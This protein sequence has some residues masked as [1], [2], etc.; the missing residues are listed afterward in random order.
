MT[1]SMWPKQDFAEENPNPVLRITRE[2]Q[3]L[4][5]N[6]SAKKVMH[7]FGL[8]DD[9]AL[10]P[11]AWT[12]SIEVACSMRQRVDY[13]CHAGEA[14][15]MLTFVPLRDGKH[16]NVYGVDI[17]H[18]KWVENALRENEQQMRAIIASMND[19]VF[20]IDMDGRFVVYHGGSTQ[21]NDT[22]LTASA[23]VG[24]RYQDVLLPE[25]GEKLEDA[26][27]RVR[28][29]LKA[30][31]FTYEQR[32]AGETH[33]FEAR[34][35]PLI[36]ADIKLTGVTVVVSDVSNAVW[37]RQRSERLL[38]LETLHHQIAIQFLQSE[39]VD[40]VLNNIM[41]IVGS[42]LDVSRVYVFQYQ[43]GHRL[44]DNTHEWCAPGVSPEIQELQ[45]I[46]YD[47]MVPSF[48]PLLLEQ[49]SIAPRHISELPDDI[50]AILSP[51]G[52]QTL[53]IVPI[54]LHDRLHGF[55]GMDE[56]RGPR[57]W[58]TE[59]ASLLRLI[60]NSF[61]RALEQNA[62]RLA[63]IEAHD[64][65]IQS[66]KL[67]SEF[68]AKMSHEIR[69]PMTG[70]LGMLELLRETDLDE[71]QTIF[72]RD[73]HDSATNLLALVDDVLDFSK[74]EA[75]RLELVAEP[76]DLRA[77]I[78]QVRTTLL[79]RVNAKGL[80]FEVEVEPQIPERVLGDP[81]RLRQVLMNLAGNAVKFTA[82][83]EVRI[84]V[85]QI[86]EFQGRVRLR[87][88]VEDSGI[89]IADE[90]LNR[91]FDSFVQAD[92]SI[93]RSFGGSGLGLTISKLLVEL[94]GGEIEVASTPGQGSTF[95]FSLTLPVQS[96]TQQPGEQIFEGLRT[97]V[98]GG[99]DSGRYLLA[100]QL[101][102]WQ[103]IVQ[104]VGAVVDL[105]AMLQR[106]RQDHAPFKLLLIFIEQP[107]DQQK[108]LLQ[109]VHQAMGSEAPRIYGIVGQTPAAAGAAYDGLLRRPVSA[110]DLLNVLNNLVSVGHLPVE[111]GDS[112]SA[113][114]EVPVV[115]ILVA[116][117]NLVNQKLVLNAL[118]NEGY[119]ID[120][121]QTGR[122]ALD[123]HTERPY[124][125]ILMDVRMPEMD[126]IT[127]TRQIRTLSGAAGKV[128]I[129]AL[130]A[131]V[132]REERQSYEE[133]GMNAI[134]GK[135]FE[136]RALRELVRDLLNGDRS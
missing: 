74:I 18:R 103:I 76:M 64:A 27:Q 119:L 104:E 55:I 38:E 129:V 66:V 97:L 12:P 26:V 4:Y 56:V 57:R 49:G 8:E 6:A 131:S 48:T 3:L 59:E 14:V 106:T 15:F 113:S 2:R 109:Q 63:L 125:L 10:V 98:M 50:R 111:D 95:S 105:P 127:A 1:E 86:H 47:E 62:S 91:I 58:L 133:I 84:R 28:A 54:Y 51:Q 22:P 31:Y 126:G 94:M 124:D 92:N 44:L 45:G 121:A 61:A 90:N 11:E 117:D 52:I 67:K 136:L 128:P 96:H 34:V 132:L 39:S 135:P 134:M 80:A 60:A 69:T 75:G 24:K 85:Q 37:A 81:T 83:G 122:E 35:S 16:L 118:R 107:P 17:S 114:S 100:E 43:E 23:F 46:P 30:V 71:D 102:K 88:A 123:R 65:A 20:S 13:E 101:R 25:A 53:L 79:P 41:S 108:M 120:I 78:G 82:Q 93:T 40:D 73:A 29:D 5:A 130:T 7:S 115:R 33:H 19:Q 116:E 110:S 21:M 9:S 70:V 32:I 42:V 36:S 72:A 77:V 87:F 68:M 99:K 89:G 112:E